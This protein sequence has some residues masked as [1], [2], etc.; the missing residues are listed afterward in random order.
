MTKQEEIIDLYQKNEILLARLYEKYSQKFPTHF[1]FWNVLVKD[2]EYHAKILGDLFL[3][4]KDGV[5]VF[6]DKRFKIG[7][8]KAF[9]ESVKKELDQ[10]ES[11]KVDL[12]TALT[13]SVYFEEAL[14]EKDYFVIFESDVA[15]LKNTLRVLKE[16]SI[17]HLEYVRN[18]WKEERAVLGIS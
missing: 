18:K 14:I 1:G 6:D 2:E 10:T 12:I 13:A 16:G 17:L 3:K 11:S 5:V 4:I 9:Y 15:E 8:L 7:N